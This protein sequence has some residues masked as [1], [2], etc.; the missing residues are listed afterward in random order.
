[1]NTNIPYCDYSYANEVT[2]TTGDAVKLSLI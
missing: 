1:M 2:V